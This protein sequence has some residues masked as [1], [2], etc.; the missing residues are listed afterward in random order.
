MLTIQIQDDALEKELSDL[1]EQ[2]FGGDTERMLQE[3]IRFYSAQ[4]NRLKYS[5]IL[6]WEKDGL[7]YQKEV[8]SEW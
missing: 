2:K 3:L 6:Q 8:R 1:L 4:N 7:E 5:G